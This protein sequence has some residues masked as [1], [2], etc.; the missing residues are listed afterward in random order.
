MA[1]IKS[2]T[3]YMVRTHNTCALF[4]SATLSKLENLSIKSFFKNIV[5]ENDKLLL[6]Y[7][8]LQNINSFVILITDFV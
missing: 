2:T 1:Y 3:C 7:M 6:S 5:F 8:K 4:L